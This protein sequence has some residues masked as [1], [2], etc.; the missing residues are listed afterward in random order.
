MRREFPDV[1]GWTFE[2]REVSACAFVVT[3][4][5]EQGRNIER[6]GSDV[7]AML[8]DCRLWAR[9]WLLPSPGPDAAGPMPRAGG[10]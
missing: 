3:G 7:D 2:V 10:P 4:R 9:Q 8:E 5:D 6:I 1:P